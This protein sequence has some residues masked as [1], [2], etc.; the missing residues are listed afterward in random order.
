[1]P[2][3]SFRFTKYQ[4]VL[5]NQYDPLL[6]PLSKSCFQSGLLFANREYE[7]PVREMF[8]SI[9]CFPVQLNPSKTKYGQLTE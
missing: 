3:V 6:L 7:N 2:K 1:M 4:S 9:H 8:E 5:S